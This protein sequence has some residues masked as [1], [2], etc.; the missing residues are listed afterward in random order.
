VTAKQ[1]HVSAP[2]AA[3][4]EPQVWEAEVLEGD[5]LESQVL[6]GE[7]LDGE[8]LEGEVLGPTV[9]A[10]PERTRIP[11]FPVDI[12]AVITKALKAAGL[13]KGG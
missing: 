11:P 8:V 2:A 5:V 10:R 6:E 7:V 13:M 9:N 1:P 3:L 4:A 12:G